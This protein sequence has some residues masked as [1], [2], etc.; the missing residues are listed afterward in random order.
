MRTRISIAFLVFLLTSTSQVLAKDTFLKVLR[1]SGHVAVVK[2]SGY[3][4]KKLDFEFERAKL[5]TDVNLRE[6]K[7]V[8]FDTTLAAIEPG[9]IEDSFDVF[10]LADGVTVRGIFKKMNSSEVKALIQEDHLEPRSL[11]LASIKKVTFGLKVLDVNRR[12]FGTGFNLFGKDIE[13]AL[14]NAFAPQV[15]QEAQPLKDAMAD[16]YLNTLGRRIAAAS[17]RPDLDYTFKVIDSEEINAFTIGGGRVYVNRGLI[18]QTD[19]ESELAGVIAHE[20]GHNV[21]KHTAKNLSKQLLYYG[22]TVGGS[23]LIEQKSEKWAEVFQQAG[24]VVS[25]FVMMK[26]SRDDEREADYLGV[27]N[28]YEIGYDPNGMISL[29]EKF[30]KMQGYE[31]SR[32]EVFFQTHP[33]PSERMENAG[34]EIA[35]LDVRQLKSDDPEFQTVK[36]H[37]QQLPRP[38]VSPEQPA[39]CQMLVADD[40]LQVQAAGMAWYEFTVDTT[41]MKNCQLKG[42]F[43]ASGGAG[44]DIKAD[45]FDQVNF[46]NWKNGHAASSLYSSGQVTAAKVD[47]PMSQ[48]GIYYLTF[49]NR[50]S[51]FTNKAIVVR[52]AAEFTR[53]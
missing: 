17:K 10:T 39:L 2:F 3:D 48:S 53:K 35:K 30:K 9:E 46:L 40:T 50:F 1:R 12:E 6:I 43:V 14:A 52:F 19:N 37:L 26:Y 42:E 5:K 20:I 16:D 29:F 13:V 31:P 18:E 7:V 49:D 33:K 27:Y 47:L 51:L 21:G 22:I 23:E 8:C 24:G 11:P 34:V 41:I 25:F 45:I 36:L 38:T 28:L 4:D 15:E 44:N 32:L